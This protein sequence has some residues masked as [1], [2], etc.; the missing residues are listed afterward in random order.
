[1]VRV[2]VR[3]QSSDINVRGMQILDTGPTAPFPI[4]LTI[5]QVASGN[6]YR[7]MLWTLFEKQSVDQGRHFRND[8]I[9]PG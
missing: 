5:A 2:I 6:V 1:M 3:I 4:P 7:H 8:R 9:L